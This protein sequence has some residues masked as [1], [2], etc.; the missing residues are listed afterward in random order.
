MPSASFTANQIVAWNLK[1]ARR[2]RGWTQEQAADA[3]EP[4]LGERW[5]KASFSA[6][7]RS[8][9]PGATR[10]RQFTA[11]DLVALARAFELPLS[12]FFRPPGWADDAGSTVPAL[13]LLDLAFDVGEEAGGEGGWLTGREGALPL[14]A[15][16]TRALRRWRRNLEAAADHREG[17]VKAFEAVLSETDQQERES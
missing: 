16:T 17:Q 15:P 3:L 1:Q 12:Y 8:A 13:D 10:V 5:S 14:T 11:D 6:A 9:E 2:R 7:E 4:H